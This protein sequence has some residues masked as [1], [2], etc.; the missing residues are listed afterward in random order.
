MVERYTTMLQVETI[1]IDGGRTYTNEP[2]KV[3]K[4]SAYD[5]AI[6]ALRDL[7]HNNGSKMANDKARELV[8]FRK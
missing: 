8:G 7:L 5:E 3:V 2:C 4:A 6:A 1:H